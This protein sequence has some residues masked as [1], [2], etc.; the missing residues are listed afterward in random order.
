MDRILVAYATWTGAT[1]GVAEV[2]AETLRSDGTTVDVRRAR[3]VQDL[4]PYKAVALGISVHMFR[5]PAEIRRFV[6]RHRQALSH[7]PVAYFVGDGLDAYA[8]PA[9]PGLTACRTR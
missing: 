1:R 6:K 7:M 8:Q 4:S 3:E 2:I 5:V 9:A